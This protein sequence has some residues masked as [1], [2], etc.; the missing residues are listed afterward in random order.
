MSSANKKIFVC[1]L[2][3]LISIG[4]YLLDNEVINKKQRQADDIFAYGNFMFKEEATDYTPDK[5]KLCFILDDK[6]TRQGVVLASYKYLFNQGIYLNR[7]GVQSIGY[8]SSR[9]ATEDSMLI[10][11][12]MG[13][14]DKGSVDVNFHCVGVDKSVKIDENPKMYYLPYKINEQTPIG[15]FVISIE[16]E[17]VVVNICTLVAVNYDK[18][19]KESEILIG[20]Y[21]YE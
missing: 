16:D 14:T 7:D 6:S 12:F 19:Y 11:Q 2:A 17:D 1:I 5:K 20:E 15:D 21:L 9:R 4:L 13:Y 8:Y 3:G 18:Q 10:I